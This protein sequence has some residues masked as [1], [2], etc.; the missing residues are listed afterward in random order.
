MDRLWKIATEDLPREDQRGSFTDLR[1]RLRVADRISCSRISVNQVTMRQA[2]LA[3]NRRVDFQ[4]LH[5]PRNV[6]ALHFRRPAF[7]L[8]ARPSW[9]HAASFEERW[10]TRAYSAG[11]PNGL[12][13]NGAHR[14]RDLEACV[15]VFLPPP[16]Y[17]RQG[18][19]RRDDGRTR[20]T[21][22]LRADLIS[23]RLG[24]V[25]LADLCRYRRARDCFP[26]LFLRQPIIEQENNGCG[27]RSITGNM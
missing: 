24:S 17:A 23:W 13:R 8:R 25:C 18:K 14:S 10:Q 4:I 21:L 16:I 19:T 20:N 15:R 3:R 7:D 27:P 22:P 26:C 2:R 12:P 1:R 9:L 11:P 6:V 5:I